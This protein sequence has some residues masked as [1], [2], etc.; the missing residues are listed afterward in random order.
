MTNHTAPTPSIARPRTA[1][2]GVLLLGLALT[3]ACGN[4]DEQDTDPPWVAALT[5]WDAT[6]LL[7]LRGYYREP[8]VLDLATGKQTGK[9]NLS[10]Y[11][12]D[13]EALGDGAFVARH[14]QSIDYLE[15]DGR[16]KY[17]IPG[18]VFVGSVVSADH[19]TLAYADC[20]DAQASFIGVASLQP[21]VL[22]RYSPAGLHDNIDD[23]GLAL[24]NDGSLLAFVQGW[25]VALAKSDVPHPSDPPATVPTCAPDQ[26]PEAWGAP[27]ALAMSPVE[28][29]LAVLSLDGL[30]RI[31]DVGQ[32]PACT[33]L[34]KFAAVTDAST[35]FDPHLRYAPNGSTIAV[36]V[37]RLSVADGTEVG[38]WTNEVRLF[39]AHTGAAVGVLPVGQ[40]EVPVYYQ[41][42][43]RIITDVLWSDAGDRLTVAGQSLFVQHWDVATATLLWSTKL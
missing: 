23:E 39:D 10:E 43:S 18:H 21:A 5:R 25:N 36:T 30:L 20:M 34:A 42:P 29:L 31:F 4:L 11:Y 17:S 40:E 8:V 41:S 38:M 14:N 6:H 27:S 16:I 28:N 3:S 2:I 35:A 33:M 9:L 24:S 15:S 26:G 7:A 12:R 32:Y 13:I 37:S 1:V 19:S 22:Q